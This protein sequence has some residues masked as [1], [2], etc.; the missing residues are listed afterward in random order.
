VNARPGL[1]TALLVGGLSVLL[2]ACGDSRSVRSYE[3]GVYKGADDPLLDVVSK[4]EH[5]QQLRER[6]TKGQAER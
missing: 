2:A 1:R 5:K 4:P 6:F 3:P